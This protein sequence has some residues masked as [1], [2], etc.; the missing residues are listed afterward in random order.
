MDHHYKTQSQTCDPLANVRNV[1]CSV[2][3]INRLTFPPRAQT[4]D[5][6]TDK[7]AHS[8]LVQITFVR[9]RALDYIYQEL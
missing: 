5:E 1:R 4:R 3:V 6:L 7:T 8:S 9:I 2:R